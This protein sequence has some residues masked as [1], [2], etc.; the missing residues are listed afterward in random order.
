MFAVSGYMSKT[1][2]VLLKYLSWYPKLSSV[3]KVMYSTDLSFCLI[4]I[5][6]IFIYTEIKIVF[7]ITWIE[8][9]WVYTLKLAV[10]TR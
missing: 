7:V 2:V 8:P 6:L 10:T 9:S 1:K 4:S 3:Y 5:L